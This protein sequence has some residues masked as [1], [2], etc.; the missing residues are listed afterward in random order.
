MRALLSFA[1]L[2]LTVCGAAEARTRHRPTIYRFQ[3]T[4]FSVA[5]TTAA[6]T[7]THT[8]TAAA[9]PRV[10]P[11]GTRVRVTGAGPY[12]RTYV[13][14][15]TGAKVDGRH[16]DLYVPNPRQAKRFGRKIVTVHVL[17]WGDPD[18]KRAA[19]K[20]QASARR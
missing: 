1:A 9:D 13:I 20:L 10:L 7:D 2:A 12:S 18:A 6:G 17:K 5:G 19:A 3:A 14:T 15:D 8:G 4:A 11:L 16:I